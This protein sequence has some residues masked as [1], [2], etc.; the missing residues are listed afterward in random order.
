[1]NP[2]QIFSEPTVEARLQSGELDAASAY[3]IQP[4]PFNLPYI[5]LPKEINLGD[6]ALRSEYIRTSLDLSGKTFHPE[7]LVYYAAV[8]DGS[9]QKD[10]ANTF[11]N[12]LGGP[13]QPL[14]R[15]AFYDAPTGASPL[16]A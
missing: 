8:L 4:G 7:S 3:K 9:A 10:K 2:A 13:A 5:T 15:Q 12:W 6:D 14:F 1:M 11:V 16:H